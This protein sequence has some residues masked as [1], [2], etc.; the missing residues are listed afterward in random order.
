MWYIM[1][2]RTWMFMKARAW[3]E[4][5]T[6]FD[7]EGN[8]NPYMDRYRAGNQGYAAP[9]KNRGTI[10]KNHWA[11]TNHWV[12]TSK[13]R[14]LTS[15]WCEPSCNYSMAY[16]LLLIYLQLLLAIRLSLHCT[17]PT[18]HASCG[19]F[20]LRGLAPF[21]EYPFQ[22]RCFLQAIFLRVL[23]CSPNWE[24]SNYNQN[25]N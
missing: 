5:H 25:Y 3:W 17:S 12:Y 11:T 19:T 16:R 18:F 24:S 21:L 20:P 15:Y 8:I 22:F 23:L 10:G 2:A 7:S 1:P 13:L 4:T 14:R 9:G 6:R